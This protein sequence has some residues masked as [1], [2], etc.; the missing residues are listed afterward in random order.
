M[1]DAYCPHLG[2]DLAAGGRVVGSCIECPFHG[3]RFR[4]EDGKCTHI[5]YAGKGEP[6]PALQRAPGAM[7]VPKN[8]IRK[9]KAA[10]VRAHPHAAP[11]FPAAQQLP[12]DGPVGTQRSDG[13]SYAKLTWDFHPL[14]FRN[15]P[16]LYSDSLYQFN[17]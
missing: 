6:P 2:A 10:F 11:S 1:V 7:A 3:W 5:P 13:L 4:G 9:G 8:L 15:D 14:F 17:A 12:W 16:A